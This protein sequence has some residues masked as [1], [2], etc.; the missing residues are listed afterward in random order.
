MTLTLFSVNS[1][2]KNIESQYYSLLLPLFK[3]YHRLGGLLT[4]D[5]YF[6]VLQAWKSR[7]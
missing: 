2:P 6:I 7:S 1:S 4:T 3:K 5:V